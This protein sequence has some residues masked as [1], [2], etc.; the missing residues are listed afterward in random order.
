[1]YEEIAETHPE[2]AAELVAERK[3]L[4]EMCATD[5]WKVWVEWSKK[6]RQA[7]ETVA[8][9]DVD[10]GTRET[11][12]Q[13]LLALEKFEKLPLFLLQYVQEG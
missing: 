4:L 9:R 12:R 7:L 11:A 13:S 6:T 8:L 10:S 2:L 5:G 3:A 1:M